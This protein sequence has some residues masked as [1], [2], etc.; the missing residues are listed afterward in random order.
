MYAISL[1]TIVQ[2]PRKKKIDLQEVENYLDLSG[3]KCAA[4]FGYDRKQWHAMKKHPDKYPIQPWLVC[5]IEAHMELPPETI[6]A[7][8]QKRLSL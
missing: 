7:L 8:K 2:M 1:N 5:S 3:P 4:F 6:D